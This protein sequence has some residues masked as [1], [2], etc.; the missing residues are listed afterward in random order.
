VVVEQ[1]R[2][3]A[4]RLPAGHPWSYREQ[5]ATS[6]LHLGAEAAA[7]CVLAASGGGILIA[8]GTAVTPLVWHLC[9]V[10]RRPRYDAGPPEVVEELVTAVESAQYDLLLLTAPDLPW[11]PDGIRDDPDGRHEAFEQY[12]TLLPGA[13]V[14]S[15]EQ[16][17]QQ[18][19]VAVSAVLPTCR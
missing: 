17:L 12:L 11:E 14:V 1:G 7:D 10:R 4:E 9:A 8:D 19:T 6:R 16:R 3:L 13:V 18:A 15:G 5:L 2:L